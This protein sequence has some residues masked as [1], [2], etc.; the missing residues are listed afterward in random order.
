MN[1]RALRGSDYL[2]EYGFVLER[3]YQQSYLNVDNEEHCKPSK[4][5][6]TAEYTQN[7]STQ[8]VVIIV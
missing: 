2:L 5:R 4:C 1:F 8:Q 3:L 6:G 7:N